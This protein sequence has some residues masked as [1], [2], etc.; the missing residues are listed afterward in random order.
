MGSMHDVQSAIDEAWANLLDTT[1]HAIGNGL[2]LT[3]VLDLVIFLVCLAVYSLARL[4]RRSM[5]VAIEVPLLS[6][7]VAASGSPRAG[8]S[9]R[10]LTS[11]RAD[12]P[13]FHRRLT[14]T[15]D[16]Y[17]LFVQR[18]FWLFIVLSA[19]AAPTTAAVWG[20]EL[21]FTGEALR[22]VRRTLF[23]AKDAC[24]AGF[25]LVTSQM[26]TPC[27]STSEAPSIGKRD[28]DWVWHRQR[29]STDPRPNG[30]YAQSWSLS[31]CKHLALVCGS[32]SLAFERNSTARGQHLPGQC[33]LFNI[34][35]A[36]LRPLMEFEYCRGKYDLVPGFVEFAL[37]IVYG[38]VVLVFVLTLLRAMSVSTKTRFERHAVWLTGL[39]RHDRE[40]GEEFWLSG[41]DF[42]RVAEDLKREIEKRIETV[43][44]ETRADPH[45]VKED[46][47]V[48]GVVVLHHPGE[49]GQTFC[50]ARRRVP[51]PATLVSMPVGPRALSSEPIDAAP[52][53]RP[54]ESTTGELYGTS[55]SLAPLAPPPK[56][57]TPPRSE[58]R[59][60]PK[61]RTRLAS[62][63]ISAQALDE[64][65]ALASERR[66]SGH[67][68]VVM[69]RDAYVDALLDRSGRLCNCEFA[70]RMLQSAS[71][72]GRRE[73][74]LFKFGVPP[75]S[76]VTLRCQ[77]APPASDLFL[78]NLHVT[79]KETW[80]TRQIG[81]V[82][83]LLVSLSLVA[84]VSIAATAYEILDNI[85]DF[86]PGALQMTPENHRMIGQLVDK[87]PSYVLLLINSVVIPFLIT[88]L[89]GVSKPHLRSRAEA[90][91]FR[92]NMTY[93]L[94][95]AFVL[96][97]LGML[98]TNRSVLEQ[99]FSYFKMLSS[100]DSMKAL[101]SLGSHTLQAPSD[102]MLKYLMNSAFITT[103]FQLLQL[104]KGF[105]SCI[106]GGKDLSWPFAWG[107]WYAW[108]MSIFVI[109]LTMSV[110]M[111]SAL[112][113]GALFFGNMHHVHKKCFRHGVFDLKFE[114]DGDAEISIVC[115][116]LRGVA[117]FW[118]FMGLFFFSQSSDDVRLMSVL[119][120]EVPTAGPLDMHLAWPPLIDIYLPRGLCFFCMQLL[121]AVGLFYMSALFQQGTRLG[122]KLWSRF[123][124]EGLSLLKFVSRLVSVWLVY[125]AVSHGAGLLWKRKQV[126]LHH[127][128]AYLLWALA[129]FV[130][131]FTLLVE[132]VA[133]RLAGR[134]QSMGLLS[135][136][137]IGHTVDL[138]EL[139][140]EPGTEFLQDSLWGFYDRLGRLESQIM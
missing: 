139:R 128:A 129:A 52:T 104:G 61:L 31:A 58:Q 38:V 107:Y 110:M 124:Q 11:A 135:Q 44:L 81:G 117:I 2:F 46:N 10:S 79:W 68:F 73:S 65:E 140:E 67:A 45:F 12:D 36:E 4:R 63:T 64:Q 121:L 100:E 71:K 47:K 26:I 86:T 80:L 17:L 35:S 94:L 14:P 60:S 23:E 27:T 130:L 103:G 39:P 133:Q 126:P 95:N 111:P 19:I 137:E 29:D 42:A 22:S 53:E 40:D 51:A 75:W 33:W 55:M 97:L 49:R 93:L 89:T 54:R 69:K 105:C 87:L 1:Q 122:A 112:F 37:T 9:T 118:T 3:F 138:E 119:E 21:L 16:N 123:G 83:L 109:C 115:W 32:N 127:V 25:P 30:Y 98:T 13:E 99:F 114:M 125:F 134:S 131:L 56:M 5:R 18:G 90:A 48:V 57:Q 24:T 92:L 136:L 96:P 34:E 76:K 43:L 88:I 59:H 101:V 116:M 50:W 113:M 62:R 8:A 132:M 78:K 120:L 77:R 20:P 85:Q 15:A 108:C 106:Y 102:L 84:P 70:R 66:L 6:D 82:I 72:S 74:T 91:I 7:D 41:H 28:D